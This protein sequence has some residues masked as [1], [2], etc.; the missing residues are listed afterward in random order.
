M[1]SLVNQA[2]ADNHARYKQNTLL[3][4]D[5]S[6]VRQELLGGVV[7]MLCI[8]GLSTDESNINVDEDLMSCQKRNYCNETHV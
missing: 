2:F 4:D 7:V 5:G 8:L 1:K 3:Y 6:R